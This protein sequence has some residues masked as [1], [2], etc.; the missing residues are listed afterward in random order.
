MHKLDYLEK[1]IPVIE[2]KIGY[3]FKKKSLLAL[4]F[5]HRSF[6]NENRFIKTGHN[7]RLEFLGDA[8]LGLVVSDFLYSHLPDKPEG[9]LSYLRSRLVEAPACADYLEHL[10]VGNFLLMGKGEA[11]NKGKGRS[12][13]LSD[14]F[15]AIVGALY[16][17]GGI[18]VVKTFFSNHFIPKMLSV[19]EKPDR[20]WKAE[21]QDYCQKNYQKPPT[22]HL[23]KEEG[24]DHLKCFSI[25]VK[26]ERKELGKGEGTSKKE[27][28]QQAAKQAL[29]DLGF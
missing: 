15:E 17:D 2:E 1:G 5:I 10:Q 11:M 21:L 4:A 22:Y 12:S 16:L 23:I 29:K 7:E 25:V 27:A 26:I 18:E 28:E 6:T 24:P 3:S 9:E 19:I 20:N 13:V 8:I 14:L